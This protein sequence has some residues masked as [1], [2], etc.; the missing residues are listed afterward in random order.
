MAEPPGGAVTATYSPPGCVPLS[1]LLPPRAPAPPDCEPEVLPLVLPELPPGLVPL[2]P[3]LE[4]GELGEFDEVAPLPWLPLS[5]L[6]PPLQAARVAENNKAGARSKN[7]FMG[8]ISFG[9]DAKSSD[10]G[11]VDDTQSMT[12]R[13]GTFRGVAGWL[14]GPARSVDRKRTD[15]KSGV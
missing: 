11:A 3:G 7:L 14:Q 8:W 13:N 9:R 5:P 10:A 15:Q 2:A 12:D 4:E 1:G 6:P